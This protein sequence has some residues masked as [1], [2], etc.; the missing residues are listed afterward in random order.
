MTLGLIILLAITIGGAALTYLIED[1]EP[2]L[3]RLAAGCVIGSAIFG[4]S[5]FLLGFALGIT[6]AVA[7]AAL[8]MTLLPLLLLLDND[9]RKAFDRDRVLARGRLQGAT[10]IKFL[11]FLYYAVFLGLLVLFFDRAIIIND[12]GIF[13]GGSKNLWDPPFFLWAVFS[14]S[15]GAT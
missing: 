13:T 10:G 12:Q 7:L 1:D 4:F 5:G 14:F 15:Q 3:W 2:L 6:P 11:R 8:V 9:C